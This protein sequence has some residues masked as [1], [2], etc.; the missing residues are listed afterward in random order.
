M[1]RKKCPQCGYANRITAKVCA[2]CAYH[3]VAAETHGLRK[4]CTR[5]GQP[6][7]IRAKVCTQ[8]GKP[9]RAASPEATATA[10]KWCT[11]CGKPRRA[12]AKVCSHCGYHFRRLIPVEPPVKPFT[13]APITLP[14]QFDA[15]IP[16]PP[17]DEPRPAPVVQAPPD[18][19]LDS[20]GELAPF[21]SNDELN[22]LRGKGVY[23]QK[24][25]E[26]TLTRISKKR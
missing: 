6:N 12:G 14:Q 16:L 21:I 4:F 19:T 15:P 26:R 7:K 11:Q 8:C 13:D 2:N 22:Q 9:F 23:N 3:F 25:V 10:R 17:A 5:C 18:T 1:E 24:T 20:S